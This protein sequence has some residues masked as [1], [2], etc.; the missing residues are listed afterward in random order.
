[1]EFT[2]RD[3]DHH[4]KLFNITLLITGGR[5][6]SLVSSPSFMVPDQ[7]GPDRL[8]FFRVALNRAPHQSLPPTQ[9]SQPGLESRWSSL[10]PRLRPPLRD[11]FI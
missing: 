11:P 5:G 2:T 8:A 9:F 3:S 6:S 4:G 10:D 7:P 1:M